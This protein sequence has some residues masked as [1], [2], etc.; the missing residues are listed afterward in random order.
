MPDKEISRLLEMS[1]IHGEDDIADARLQKL[2][3][4]GRDRLLQ[5]LHELTLDSKELGMV[6]MKLV[7]VYPS[8]ETEEKLNAWVESIADPK[9]KDFMQG[10]I[11]HLK[12]SD[13]RW[14]NKSSPD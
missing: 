11:T 8:A 3:A 6:I 7:T 2:G 12:S 10:M 9:I 4:G 13:P 1:E 5:R 14:K